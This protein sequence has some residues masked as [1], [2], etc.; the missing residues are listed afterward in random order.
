MNEKITIKDVAKERVICL[1]QENF[2]E[3]VALKSIEKIINW[4]NQ[5]QI[6]IN[7]L[8]LIVFT[9]ENE[10]LVCLPIK[11]AQI[12]EEGEYKIKV[13]PSHRMASIFHNDSAKP[14]RLS[15]DF[16]RRRLRYDGLKETGDKRY[17]FC[18]NPKDPKTVKVEIQIPIQG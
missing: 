2:S 9:K 16:L 6:S 15:E 8:P 11:E 12:K 17:L 5:R 14:I 18:P 10:Y 1:K 13:L 7:G 4:L 3:T